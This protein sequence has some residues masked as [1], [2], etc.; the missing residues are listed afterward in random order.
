MGS[1]KR[2]AKKI[3]AGCGWKKG[4]AIGRAVFK[5]TPKSRHPLFLLF[6]HATFFSQGSG[7]DKH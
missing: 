1:R 7:L 5:P 2:M 4:S 6:L 3:S